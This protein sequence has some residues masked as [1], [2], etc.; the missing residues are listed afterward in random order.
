MSNV[1]SITNAYIFYKLFVFKT[2]GNIL[3][4][5]LKCYSVYGVAALCGMCMIYVF[6]DIFGQE[7][8]PSNV[9][10]TILLSVV[11]FV[12]HKFFS[13]AKKKTPKNDVI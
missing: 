11:S 1:I 7:P 6:V 3:R 13:F 10:V 2:K 8:I 12:G 5:Y 4:E 9:V